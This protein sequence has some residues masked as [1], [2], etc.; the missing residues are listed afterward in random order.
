MFRKITIHLDA[1]ICRCVDPKILWNHDSTN[2]HRSLIVY[3]GKCKAEE[4]VSRNKFV[5]EIIISPPEENS[6][7]PIF[8]SSLLLGDEAKKGKAN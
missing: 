6:F 3:C 7:K 4:V 8:G 2:E 5:G 1:P